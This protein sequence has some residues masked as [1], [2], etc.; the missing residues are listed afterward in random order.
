MKVINVQGRKKTGKTTTVTNIIAEL[1][2]RGYS[3][4]SVKGIHIDGFTM[5]SE[6]EDT[7]K[8]KKA[9]ADPVTALCNDE[10]NI[11]FQGRMKLAEVLKHYDCDWVVIEGHADLGCPNIVTGLSAEY[12][13][14]GMDRSLAEQV[15]KLTIAC[16]GIVSNETDEFRGIPVVNSRTDIGK[17]VDIIEGAGEAAELLHDGGGICPGG[18][19]RRC[20]MKTVVIAGAG[21][22]AHAAAE[23]L[24]TAN[25][26]F[27]GFADN[28][29]SLWNEDSRPPV[30]SIDRA[31][32][33]E[34]EVIIVSAMDDEEAR[35]MREQLRI[36]RFYGDIYYL[37]ELCGIFSIL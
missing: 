2:R 18:E 29:R 28:D 22:A 37:K 31:V 34:P 8:H 32:E 36:C 33:L 35:A 27:L 3:V 1:C 6:N 19:N 12:D 4:G 10:T 14:T 5:D 23:H 16:S 21:E 11:M 9:G 26:E 30:F 13:G 20:D 7:G 17:L 15:N 24:N 25:V